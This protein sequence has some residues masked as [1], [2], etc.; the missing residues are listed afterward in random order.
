LIG[1][2]FCGRTNSVVHHSIFDGETYMLMPGD[3]HAVRPAAAFILK[4][5][6]FD[7][8]GVPKAAICQSPL[9]PERSIAGEKKR[10]FWYGSCMCV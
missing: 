9:F 4:S 1:R 5:C 10:R 6:S 8:Y 3:R 2:R 7:A